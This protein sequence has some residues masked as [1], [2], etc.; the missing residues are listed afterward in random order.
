MVNGIDVKSLKRFTGH[1][2]ECYQG[3]V[4]LDGKRLGF[5]SQDSWGGP[6]TFEFD[7]SLLDKACADYKDGFPE[8]YMYKEVLDS[9]DV[10]MGAVVAAKHVEKDLKRDFNNG[11][12]T[13]IYVTDG[14]HYC[15][16]AIGED[17]TDEYLL[18]KYSENVDQ[19]KSGMFK[20]K[21]PSVMVFRP[22]PVEFTINR[23]NPAPSLFYV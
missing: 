20:N 15:W 12:R 13:A 14:F 6:D 2:G 19:M 11:Y 22:G 4:Y 21:E 16:T 10:F 5:W 1:E 23:D 18:S 9:K 17:G 8:D 7:E 3:T